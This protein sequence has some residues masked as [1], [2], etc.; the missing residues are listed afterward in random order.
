MLRRALFCAAL[1]AATLGP[2]RAALAAQ[3]G[4]AAVDAAV[5]TASAA[6]VPAA[7]GR[8]EALAALPGGAW[9]ALDKRALRLHDAN[10]TER[11]RLALRAS[12]MDWR[13]G[14]AGQV[15]A[16]LLDADSQRTLGVGV[17]LARMRLAEPQPLL[18]SPAFRVS[19]LCLYRDAQGADQVFLVGD[20]GLAEQ[21]L[22]RDRAAGSEG[23]PGSQGPQG[24]PIPQGSQPALRLRT[25]A[26]PPGLERCVVDDAGGWLHAHEPG[27]GLWALRA[28]SEGMPQRHLLLAQQPLGPLRDADP[29]LA[30]LPGGL[31]VL[32]A[33]AGQ[34]HLLARQRSADGQPAWVRSGKPLAVPRAAD[35]DE[36][37]LLALPRATGDAPAAG[38]WQLAWR[39][40]P[41]AAWQARALHWA[42]T[43]AQGLPPA[44]PV[45]APSAQTE[46]VHQAGDAADD[47]AI[48][49]HPAAPERSRVLGTNKREGL[50]V[51]ALDGR[52]LQRLPV[53]RLNNVDL[54][55]RV[56][57][58]GDDRPR[59]LALA[60]HRDARALVVFEADA[61]GRFSERARLPSGL[62]DLYGLC[63]HQ[64][65]AGG[66]E[67]IANDKDGRIHRLALRMEGGRI[68]ADVVQRLA[69]ASQPEGCVADD[70]AQRLFIGEEDRGIWALDLADRSPQPRLTEVLRVGG[71][72]GVLQ[73]DVEGLALYP[74]AP[75]QPARWLVASSQ[76]NH[77]VVV[78]EAQP[79]YR[80]RGALRVGHNAG[81]GIDGVSETDGLDVSGA[82]LGAAYPQGL[83]VMQ[84]GH[85]RAPEGPQNFKLIDWRVVA[86]ALGLGEP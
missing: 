75:G 5:A 81:A 37:Q 15:R 29:A 30:L 55:Q 52:E 69:M 7:I 60:T 12:A 64:P 68:V 85:K 10:G 61:E 6:A 71:A 84:D 2:T 67:A 76:G 51:Y 82:A 44:L 62:D 13:A 48:W 38:G 25:L 50:M 21:W 53:G 34:L 11:A 79:P 32:D 46:P 54:R 20:E 42:G 70:A 58:P 24:T 18:P 78:L 39:S 49:V 22:L 56:R 72:G 23:A 47:P 74:G 40:T 86:R 1:L 66:L 65:P 28:D 36:P 33:R 63:L 83:L 73:A 4:A 45:V 9:L 19:T 41:K 8:T 16:V 57:L 43:A 3:P 27:V 14:P 80:V 31:A 59:D 26:L 35:S 77:S 17:D